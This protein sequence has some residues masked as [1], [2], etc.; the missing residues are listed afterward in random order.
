MKNP[1]SPKKNSAK[2]Q[3]QDF[4]LDASVALSWYFKDE[5]NAYA[6]SVAA[7]CA[8]S[9]IIVPSLWFLEIAN[10]IV[11]GER[12]GRST[13][14]QAATW[15]GFL[16]SLPI[17]TDEAPASG[18]CN[19]IINLARSYELSAYDAAYLELALRRS[20]PLATLDKKL[21]A[22]AKAAGIT[23]YMSHVG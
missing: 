22:A 15:L 18:T 6:D 1:L 8:T 20:L 3:A 23:L 19:N 17:I 9:N 5:A 16:E 11:M 12:R 2:K 21:R 13:V 7:A 4:I 10:I 14:A